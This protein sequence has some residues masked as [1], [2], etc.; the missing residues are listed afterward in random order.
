MAAV[1]EIDGQIV[2]LETK[3]FSEVSRGFTPFQDGDVLFAKITPCMEN[4]KAAIAKGLTNGI[5]FGS[6]EFHV[7]RP[8]EYLLA[9]Y[10]FYF[11]RQATFR[12]HAKSAFIGSAGQQRVPAVF[13]ERFKIPLPSLTE[14]QGIVEIL[15]HAE[16]LSRIRREA[17]VQANQIESLTFFEMFGDPQINIHGWPTKKVGDLCTLV[18]G[19]SP[20][21]QGDPRYFGGSV[22]RLMVADLTRDGLY[23]TP[24]IDSLTEE[25]AKRSR[26]M[27]A[28]DVVMAVSGAPGLAAIL[29]T[30]A[31]IHDGFVG[32]RELSETLVPE[33]FVGILDFYRTRNVQQATGAIFLNLTTDQVNKWK[34]PIPLIDLQQRYKDAVIAHHTV[35]TQMNN[36]GSELNALSSELAFNAFSGTLTEL[37]RSAHPK[38]A[39]SFVKT[40]IEIKERAPEERRFQIQTNRV[41]LKDQLSTLQGCVWRAMQEWKGTLIPS[42]DI[43]EFAKSWPIEHLENSNDHIL[44]A[45]TQLAGMGLVAKI[46][47]GNQ[48]GEYVTAYRSFREEEFSLPSDLEL[49]QSDR[50]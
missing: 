19:S 21:P 42:Q 35:V 15:R 36:I 2:T 27:N 23:V 6:T 31:C 46:R 39:H 37:W 44:R 12:D 20:R 5:G 32:F 40:S 33:Y 48:E 30:D 9:E 7:L 1:D 26:P 11:I 18:R 3:P 17:I 34:V 50:S 41:W 38:E 4:G 47:I 10:L 49:L 24:Q 8:S 16:E 25:G 14:Q 45:L 22:P 28:G 29:T 43:D 13:L